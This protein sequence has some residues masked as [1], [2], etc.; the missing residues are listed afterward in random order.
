MARIP[1]RSSSR[2]GSAGWASVLLCLVAL[3]LAGCDETSP[4]SA[5][6]VPGAGQFG[7]RCCAA[8]DCSAVTTCEAQQ[9]TK[10]CAADAGSCDGLGPD[11]GNPGCTAAGFCVTPPLPVKDDDGDQGGW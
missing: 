9:C 2:L 8:S 5:Q 7:D 11:G 3:A 6:C 4:S 10:A 1:A